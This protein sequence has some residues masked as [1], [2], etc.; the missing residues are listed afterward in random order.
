M[1]DLAGGAGDRS[2]V[3]EIRRFELF[4]DGRAAS[5]TLQRP[6]LVVQ[7]E[8]LIRGL[9]EQAQTA[10]VRLLLGRRLVSFE[11]E[12]DALTLRLEGARSSRLEETR[13]TTIVGADG[14]FSRVARIAGWPKLPTAPLV[15]AVVKLPRGLEPDTTRVWFVP[16][17]TPYFYWLIPES[18]T[19][20]VL[21]LIGE[22][23]PSTRLCLER[24][25]EKQ[26]LDPIEFQAARIPV[27]T[28]WTPTRRRVGRNDVYLVGD[29]GGQVKVT[30]VGGVVTGFRGA[31]GVAEAI[32]NGGRSRKLRALRREL[33]LHLLIRRVL[34]RFTQADY[35]RL[36]DL[37][38]SSTRRLLG[39][40][41]RDDANR[42]LLHACL[43]QP[44]LLLVA[45]RGLVTGGCFP[46]GSMS[47]R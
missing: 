25:L 10:G 8:A 17:D 22:D 23:G 33:D 9:A 47:R 43:H 46:F 42:I 37:L 40:Y 13:A 45:V 30:T 12:A 16:D 26:S 39:I 27:Y 36:L 19:T 4:T 18:P 11:P 34:H 38:N 24:F 41:S 5:I 2:I 6:D 28:G 7:R 3:N 20:G 44:R 15:Q 32:L 14:A 35:S 1:R 29:A 21:G 31:L